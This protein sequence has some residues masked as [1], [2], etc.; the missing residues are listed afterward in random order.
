VQSADSK[1]GWWDGILVATM[2]RMTV[3]SMVDKT[4]ERKG[5]GL[6]ERMVVQTVGNSVGWTVVGLAAWSVWRTVE[7]M[8]DDLVLT[9]AAL[10][11]SE[12]VERKEELLVDY[13]VA[14]KVEKTVE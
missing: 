3:E 4:V 14:S 7:Q 2:A 1:V 13:E 10:T 9:S 12:M 11:E 5:S 6:V 8:A